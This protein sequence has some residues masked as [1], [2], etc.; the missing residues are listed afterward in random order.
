M[1]AASPRTL[2]TGLIGVVAF[3]RFPGHP[4]VQPMA[5]MG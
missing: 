1:A 4:F 2:G 3:L 5:V